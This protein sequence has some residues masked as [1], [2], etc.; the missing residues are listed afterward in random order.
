VNKKE[1]ICTYSNI[2]KLKFLKLIL[3]K[4]KKTTKNKNN[5]NQKKNPPKNPD[6]LQSNMKKINK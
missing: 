5:K 2:L 6:L 4:K 1:G 3:F